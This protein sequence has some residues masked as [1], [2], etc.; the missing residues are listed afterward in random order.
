MSISDSE[1]RGFF[2]VL[3]C[4]VTPLPFF[5]LNSVRLGVFFFLFSMHSSHQIFFPCL[6]VKHEY[7]ALGE[8]NGAKSLGMRHH[9]F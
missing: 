2:F 6:Y 7:G 8:W 3:L 5:L 1:E 4:K 9:I